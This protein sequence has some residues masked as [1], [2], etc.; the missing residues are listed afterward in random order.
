MLSSL[1]QT[2][3]Y[4][5]TT[6]SADEGAI[7]GV[8]ALFTGVF[9]IVWLAV[10]AVIVVSM[11][12]IFEKA[13]EEGWKAL[14]PFYNGW[15]L[16]EISGKPGWWAL[17]GLGSIIP[18]LGFIAGI[19]AFILQIIISIELAKSF[20]KEPVWA[21]LLIFVPIIGFPMLAFGDAKYVGPGG[22]K[23]GGTKAKTA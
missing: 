23:S 2:Y 14:I 10:L 15:V 13:G 1:A 19:A 18:F 17:V 4:T 11:W 8:L 20:G 9:L 12:K 16:A 21:L 6:T 3:T 7:A 22:K 5:T